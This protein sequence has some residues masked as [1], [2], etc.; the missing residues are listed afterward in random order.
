MPACYLSISWRDFRLPRKYVEDPFPRTFFDLTS[1]PGGPGQFPENGRG[2]SHLVHLD[3][4][5]EMRAAGRGRIRKRCYT[6]SRLVKGGGGVPEVI[7]GKQSRDCG[8]EGWEES[9]GFPDLRHGDPLPPGFAGLCRK[10]PPLCGLP[11][12]AKPDMLR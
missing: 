2:S 4:S 9:T 7:S 3:Q 12:K 11:S 8:R 5:P 6:P 10:H 1:H